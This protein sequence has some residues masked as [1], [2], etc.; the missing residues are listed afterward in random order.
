MIS[1]DK[2]KFF[3]SRLQTIH[4]ATDRW[5]EFLHK[6]KNHSEIACQVELDTG[7]SRI[8][9]VVEHTSTEDWEELKCF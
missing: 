7:P 6:R 4:M 9:C 8:K 1:I 2:C 3:N 5:Q